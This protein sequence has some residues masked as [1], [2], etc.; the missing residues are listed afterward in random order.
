MGGM[1]RPMK[2][3]RG[4]NRTTIGHDR[5]TSPLSYPRKGTE[6]EGRTS[7]EVEAEIVAA[8]TF[9][10][11][12]IDDVVMIFT[13]EDAARVSWADPVAVNRAFKSQPK[14]ST[15]QIPLA[16]SSSVLQD[17]AGLSAEAKAKALLVSYWRGLAAS[18]I[19]E[20]IA[21]P[22]KIH[23]SYTTGDG[24]RGRALLSIGHPPLL[25]PLVSA[26][27][28]TSTSTVSIYNGIMVYLGDYDA[29]VYVLG[30][31]IFITTRRTSLLQMTAISTKQFGQ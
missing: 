13:A 31:H 29:I 11:R 17:S 9:L 8:F 22:K 6:N 28:P 30:S 15:K 27:G 4:V 20:A 23:A 19:K 25:L 24:K 26:K 12:E 2:R 14:K 5:R 1:G 16:L 10:E 3:N 7:E 21:E 18:G